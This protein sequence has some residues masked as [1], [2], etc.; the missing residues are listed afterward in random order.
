MNG[1]SRTAECNTEEFALQQAAL[2]IFYDGLMTSAPAAQRCRPG[3]KSPTHCAGDACAAAC[4][5]AAALE[6]PAAL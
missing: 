4:G 2:P 6:C 1:F 5:G 3:E